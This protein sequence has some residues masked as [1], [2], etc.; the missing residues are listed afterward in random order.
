M[1]I[2]VLRNAVIAWYDSGPLLTGGEPQGKNRQFKN[3]YAI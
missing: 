2:A 3:I 1:Q